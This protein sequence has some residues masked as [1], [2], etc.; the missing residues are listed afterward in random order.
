MLAQRH[1]LGTKAFG[2][3]KLGLGF[4]RGAETNALGAAAGTQQ[5]GQGLDCRFR[6]AKLI[7]QGP[8]GGGANVSAAD[9]P[10]P[11]DPLTLVETR[12]SPRGIGCSGQCGSP[13]PS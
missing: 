9:Q 10:E 2:R 5:C 7:D 1:E 11:S 12:A 3:L 4:H 13:R 6:T 8:E